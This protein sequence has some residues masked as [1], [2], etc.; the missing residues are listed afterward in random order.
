[1]DRHSLWNIG[2]A[3]LIY[4]EFIKVYLVRLDYIQYIMCDLPYRKVHTSF[5]RRTE[6][7]YTFIDIEL[8]CEVMNMEYGYIRVSSK[9]QHLD[10]QIKA[11]KEIGLEDKYIYADK[12]SGA[13]FDRKGY[14]LL[15]GT[16]TTAPLL[17]EG[18][19]LFVYSIDR[20][21]R[22]Y[23][24]ILEQWQKI[25]RELKV[26]ICVI[27]MPLLDTRGVKDTLDGRFV[28]DLVLQ[29]LSYVAERERLNNRERQRMGIDVAKAQ[30]RHL[31][32]PKM[33]ISPAFSYIYKKWKD[34]EIS[35]VKAYTELK[36][37][38]SSFYKLIKLYESEKKMEKT[39]VS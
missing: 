38:K 23:Q 21:G 26:D 27:D 29:I 39:E 13:T 5:C 9:E 24:E 14:N 30:G 17:R 36:M 6:N 34:G 8:L 3:Y 7:R 28:S 12:A 37:P 20:L 35:A 22:N 1:M 32:R 19:T 11:M 10:R 31:G 16:E 18:D 2:C 4:E 15:V 33:Q 25:T